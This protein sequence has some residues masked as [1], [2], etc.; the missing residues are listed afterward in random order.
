M[1]KWWLQQSAHS[2]KAKSFSENELAEMIADNRLSSSA[3]VSRDGKSWVPATVGLRHLFESYRDQRELEPTAIPPE[4]RGI[5]VASIQ[6][7]TNEAAPSSF[8]PLAA[9]LPSQTVPAAPYEGLN[10]RPHDS[11]TKLTIT[12]AQWAGG[13]LVALGIAMFLAYFVIVVDVIRTSVENA[14]RERDRMAKLSPDERQ[15]AERFQQV[16][17]DG[18]SASPIFAV[19]GS[20][21]LMLLYLATI[22]LFS[23]AIG[24]AII[25]WGNV[26]KS[27]GILRR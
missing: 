18:S 8:L 22:P 5:P 4:P 21:T 15:R 1:S 16:I 3:R 7:E 2:K 6:V 20:A 11:S 23:I 9:T 17:D 24:M 26:A 13:A 27:R 10:W 25:A 12:L 19:L 14:A